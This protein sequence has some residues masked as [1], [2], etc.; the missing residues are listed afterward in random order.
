MAAV[1]EQDSPA[2]SSCCYSALPQIHEYY[3]VTAPI[4]TASSCGVENEK[5]STSF[6]DTGELQH[7]MNKED[8]LRG[9][10]FLEFQFSEIYTSVPVTFKV[11]LV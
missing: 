11:L 1:E 7:Y 5:K 9:R 3:S 2:H 8:N 4:C 6:H 10:V